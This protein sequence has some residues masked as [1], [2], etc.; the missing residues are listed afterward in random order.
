MTTTPI[1]LTGA[2]CGDDVY[3]RGKLFG[4]IQRWT[5]DGCAVQLAKGE[6]WICN[7]LSGYVTDTICLSSETLA[8]DDWEVIPHGSTL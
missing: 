4:H 2:K 7:G 5:R 8:G 6:R 1:H 3:R